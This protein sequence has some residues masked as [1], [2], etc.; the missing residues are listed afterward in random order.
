MRELYSQIGAELGK[1][2][3][4]DIWAGFSRGEFAIYNLEKVFL[5]DKEVSYDKRFLGNS[6]I[7]FEGDQLA[8]WMVEDP[9]KED[10]K[11]LAANIVHEMFHSHQYSNK[12][13]RFP[14]DLKGLDYPMDL[15]NFEIKYKENQ[16]LVACFEDKTKEQKLDLLKEIIALRNFRKKRYGEDIS[17]EFL[18]ETFEG[19]AEYCGTK[20]LKYISQTLYNERIN[21]Y[22][23]KLSNDI[24]LLFDVRR[25]AYFTG[26]LFL[27]LLDDLNINFTQ[28][29]EGQTENIF[30]QVSKE[31][32]NNIQTR[33]IKDNP[34][35][36]EKY[37]EFM[38]EKENKFKSFF[39]KE[40]ETKK[41]KA[42]ICGYDPMNMIKDKELI[43]CSHFIMLE[44]KKSD[45]TTFLKGPVVVKLEKDSLN[46]VIEYYELV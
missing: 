33:E 28:E 36:R 13:S 21:K 11:N 26:T 46:H 17:Y 29:I 7:D 22:K 39:D 1:V 5:K 6:S 2:N 38:L 41:S 4:Q 40:Y 44:N 19:S 20:S 23:N 14:N 3:F 45:E 32:K 42:L 35:I 31:F 24:E 16:L 43:L 10:R 30:D 9:V 15:R 12:E 18:V 34:E 25:L 8:I 37:K 27:L